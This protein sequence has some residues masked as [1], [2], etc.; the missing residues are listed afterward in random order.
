VRVLS[1]Y[2]FTVT[3]LLRAGDNLLEILVLNTLA[4]Y[5]EMQSPTFYIFPGQCDSGLI[6]PVRWIR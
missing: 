6:G 5:L 2:R 4:P 1:P 3:D